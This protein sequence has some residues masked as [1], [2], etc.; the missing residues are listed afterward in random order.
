MALMDIRAA[1]CFISCGV[2]NLIDNTKKTVELQFP[3]AIPF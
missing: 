1:L 2:Q 3:R